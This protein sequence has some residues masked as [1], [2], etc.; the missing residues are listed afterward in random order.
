L[1][2]FQYQ[3]PWLRT[4]AGELETALAR[5]F[6]QPIKIA[7]A[8]RTDAG[9][10]AVGQVISFTAERVAPIENLA[11]ALN[12]CL[13]SDVSV[14]S[15]DVVAD[16]F[17]A[18]FHALER[19]Y[20]YVILNRRERSATLRRFAHHAYRPLD[21]D[22]LRSAA[23]DFVGTHDF[24][25]FCGA[26]PD[27]GNTERTVY[28]VEV[29]DDPP[30]LRVRF[31]AR[32]FLHRMVRVMTGTLLE[33][34]AGRRAPDAIPKILAA[35]DRRA[36]GVTAPPHGLFFAGA[37]YADFDSFSAWDGAYCVDMLPLVP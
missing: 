14:R 20:T 3:S 23:R 17:S 29:E 18:R 12:G 28:G 34:A 2:G 11:F 36:A 30:M 8:G 32:S 9:V 15:A 4:V 10:H 35:R 13:A 5:I 27:D 31:R 21:L 16:G 33:I 22:I 25:S 7:G 19:R 24:L 26:L 1:H 37:R 6:D